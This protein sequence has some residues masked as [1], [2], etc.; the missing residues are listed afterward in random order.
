M[1]RTG[2]A[3]SPIVV[4]MGVAGCGK[5]T[6]GRALAA[7]LG[8]SYRDADAFHS[9]ANIAK[10]RASKPLD[11]GD[12]APWLAAIAGWMDRCA[13][14][15]APAVIGCSALKRRY[16]DLLRDGRP[17]VWFV[18]LRARRDELERRLQTRT[19]AFMP[20]SLVAS[21]LEALEEPTPDEPRTIT[22]DASASVD[23]IAESASC[24]LRASDVCPGVFG[25]RVPT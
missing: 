20:A 3:A 24:R 1:H 4:V 15:R 2:S 25:A 13:R 23:A 8:W 11:D 10:M 14:L 12:R 17:Q 22:L 7:Q 21:Q 18:Y 6:V 5:T 19:H 9:P 16:R